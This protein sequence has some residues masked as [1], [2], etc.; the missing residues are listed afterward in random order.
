MIRSQQLAQALLLMVQEVNGDTQKATQQF[1]LFLERNNLSNLLPNVIFYLEK[2]QQKIEQ[3]HA[4][5]ITS[6]YKLSTATVDQILATFQSGGSSKVEKT[7]DESLIGGVIV[8]HNGV[9]YDGSIKTQLVKLEESLT[10]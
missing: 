1:L 2:E 8:Q 3:A 6:P 7:V 4:F 5:S 10:K 9:I